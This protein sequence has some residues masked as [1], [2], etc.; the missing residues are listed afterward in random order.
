[1]KKVLAL[2]T[3]VCVSF[4]APPSISPKRSMPSRHCAKS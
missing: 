2:L 4:S 1:M 3:L